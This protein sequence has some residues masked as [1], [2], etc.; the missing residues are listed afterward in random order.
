MLMRIRMTVPMIGKIYVSK[1]FPIAIKFTSLVVPA[2]TTIF[3]YVD[4]PQPPDQALV[5][6]V[7]GLVE[8]HGRE[9]YFLHRPLHPKTSNHLSHLQHSS[10][11]WR[12]QLQHP[13]P[14]RH[15]P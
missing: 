2:T 7:L 1:R 15:I 3:L 14:V 6:R 11:H 8:D 13:M 9:I 4:Y 12:Q 10:R 5:F